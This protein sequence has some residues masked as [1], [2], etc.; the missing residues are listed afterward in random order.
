MLV[1]FTGTNGANPSAALTIGSDGNFYGTTERGGANG[2]GTIFALTPHGVL[3]T[4]YSFSALD[5]HGFNS[6]GAQPSA[7]L[8]SFGN[9][10]FFGTTVYGGTDGEGTVFRITTDGT[11]HGTTLTSLVSFTD[12]SGPNLGAYPY[13]SLVFSSSGVYGTTQQGGLNDT[14]TVY[15][16]TSA[17]VLTTIYNF[18]ALTGGKNA[19]GSHSNCTLVQGAGGDLY[20]TTSQG[21]PNAD[22]T[23]FSLTPNGVLTTLVAFDGT[24]G[25]APNAGVIEGADGSFYGTTSIGGANNT[26]TLYD[27]TP[28]GALTT[29]HSFSAVT[30]TYPYMNSDGA[31]PLASLIQAG[32]G[33]FYGTTYSGGTNGEGTVFRLNLAPSITSFAP[34]SGPV[35]T[36]VTITGTDLN[37]VTAVRFHN[38]SATAFSV[39]AA[40]TQLTVTVPHGAA[41]GTITVTTPSG[42]VKTVPPFTVTMPPTITSFSPTSGAGRHPGDDHGHK[43]ERRDR[44]PVS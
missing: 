8:L 23:V 40:G 31:Y 44:R 22:G 17:G 11:T 6:D 24:N 1:A 37:G 18:S 25:A 5:S 13:G 20:G 19:D 35:G 38:A 3:T 42:S 33:G 29:L 34:T 4:L 9:G 39:N 30:T 15:K 41:T 26:G 7:S 16:V 12:T 21:G 43:S 2:E 14:G 27:V 32:D 28:T 10:F 36:V